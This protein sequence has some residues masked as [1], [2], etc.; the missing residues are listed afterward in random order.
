MALGAT[1]RNIAWLVLREV[2]LMLA[3]GLAVGIPCALMGGRY[4]ESQLFG[5]Q[6]SDSAVMIAAVV[7]LTFAAI[8]A[9]YLPARRAQSRSAAGATL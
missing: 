3:A 4:V 9:G 7:I 2:A 6:A 5:V 1:R 8:L